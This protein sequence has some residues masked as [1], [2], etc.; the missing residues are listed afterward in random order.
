MYTV[1]ANNVMY[2]YNNY[3]FSAIAPTPPIHSMANSMGHAMVSNPQSIQSVQS[4]NHVSCANN[5]FFGY[6]PAVSQTNFVYGQANQCYY[7]SMPV[8]NYSM[9]STLHKSQ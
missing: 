5:Q 7:G 1:S 6:T 3:D 8:Y 4:V 2:G 9:H